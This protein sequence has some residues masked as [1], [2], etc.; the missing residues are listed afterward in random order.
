MDYLEDMEGK[1]AG[2]DRAGDCSNRFM[3]FL[4]RQC[5]SCMGY[6]DD[7]AVTRPSKKPQRQWW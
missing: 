2:E 5:H 3:Q 1:I 7:D 6:E 4:C